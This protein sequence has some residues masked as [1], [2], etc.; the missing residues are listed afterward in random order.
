MRFWDR[1]RTRILLIVALTSL[2]A[3]AIFLSYA[4]SDR[5]NALSQAAAQVSTYA[6]LK[7]DYYG[8]FATRTRGM[9]ESLAAT[10]TIT[11]GQQPDCSKILA[12]LLAR[13]PDYADFGVVNTD[14][15]L[16]CSAV[17]VTNNFNLL[18]RDSIHGA[19][20]S[21]DFTVSGYEL[22]TV[23][24]EPIVTLAQPITD[25]NNGVVTGVVYAS[26]SLEFLGRLDGSALL[27]PGNVFYLID[28][29]GLILVARPAEMPPG[30]RQKLV[31]GT[32]WKNT[33]T[34][35]GR[36]QHGRQMLYGR[37]KLHVD[38]DAS[39][40]YAMVGVPT[41]VILAAPNRLLI[42]NLSLTTVFL[43]LLGLIAWFGSDLLVLRQLRTLLAAARRIGSGDFGTQVKIIGSGELAELGWT[44]NRM[45]ETLHQ[46]QTETQLHIEQTKR[47]N[48]LYQVISAVNDAILR[49]RDRKLLLQEACRVSVELG[50]F[51]FAWAGDVDV[52]QDWV[53]PVAYTGEG[54]VY[55]QNLR[56]SVRAD[57]PEGQGIVGRAVRAGGYAVSNNIEAD[58]GMRQWWR[59][60]RAQGYRSA[61][62]FVL[63]N[64]GRA[65]G[66]LAVYSQEPGYFNADEIQLMQKVASDISYG[67][68]HI[69][70]IER[71]EYL[72]NFDTLTG[73]PNK[74]YFLA[75]LEV[76]VARA[77][78]TQKIV[79]VVVQLKELDRINDTLGYTSGD[80]AIKQAAAAIT[81]QLRPIDVLARVGDQTLGIIL[82]DVNQQQELPILVARAVQAFP[83]ILDMQQH[84]IM[85]SIVAGVATYPLD[86]L[87]AA[88][89]YRQAELMLH[90]TASET[91]TP[92]RFYTPEIDRQSAERYRIDTE[93]RYAL[94]RKELSLV[95]QPIVGTAARGVVAMEALLRWNSPKLGAVAPVN[96]IPIAE[97]NGELL[98]IGYWVMEQVCRDIQHWKSRNQKLVPVSINVSAR[99][100]QD[101]EFAERVKELLTRFHH[102]ASLLRLEI[103]ESQLMGTSEA[104]TRQLEG[105]RSWGVHLALDDFGTGYS[106]ISYINQLPVDTVKIDRSFIMRLDDVTTNEAMVKSIIG[107]ARSVI[108][109][110]VAEG[111]ETE[112]Q[113]EILKS[114][115]CDYVQ[116]YLI[117]KPIPAEQ[118]EKFLVNVE[119]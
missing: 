114:L 49:L 28:G 75:R 62:A 92:Y 73:L 13:A 83:L 54:A 69:A 86:A 9:L 43:I 103:T 19:L 96:F 111:V 41:E 113:F 77:Q 10:P 94:E 40:L 109:K 38:T 104:V 5:R 25:K 64:E 87:N 51:Y 98:R 112:R 58:T 80:D 6:R 39:D 53:Q 14:G 52:E 110:V 30:T 29:Q 21:G 56:L 4:V 70:K 15:Q 17:P 67:L 91:G 89:L 107:L 42:R 36:D 45:T 88:N 18:G 37:A 20:R 90:A 27:P 32:Q 47:I 48:R 97:E 50:G 66:V 16:L 101:S 33:D 3:F 68:E 82:S 65:I 95:Y 79:V 71:A 93:L 118:A 100:L 34:F 12:N 63:K 61:G 22:G 46:R 99:Q 31:V 74:N 7:I 55:F 84:K 116:G 60:A 85:L 44:F 72:E 119:G 1:L 76:E 24:H 11:S 106:S 117:S 2:P 102:S 59:G 105:L 35:F 78:T 81:A 57:I 8:E 108:L 26:V 23:T 115:G